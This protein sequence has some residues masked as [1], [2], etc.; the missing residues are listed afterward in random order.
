MTISRP[1][2]SVKT[3]GGSVTMLSG[4]LALKNGN[5]LGILTLAKRFNN[6]DGKGGVQLAVRG[7]TQRLRD[8]WKEC[9][10]GDGKMGE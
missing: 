3:T 1:V 7:S 2:L 5:Y 9:G 8:V 10:R 6:N 4:S